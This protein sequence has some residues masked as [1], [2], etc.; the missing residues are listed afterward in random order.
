[1]R[2]REYFDFRRKN[3]NFEESLKKNKEVIYSKV[4]YLEYIHSEFLEGNRVALKKYK[5]HQET[6]MLEEA[7]KAASFRALTDNLKNIIAEEEK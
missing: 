7:E 1:M 3:D 2:Y 4:Y 5:K 6:K